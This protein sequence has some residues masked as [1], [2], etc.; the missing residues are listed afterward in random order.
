MRND[1]LG[2][3]FSNINDSLMPQLTEQRCL[4]SVPFGGRY[5]LIDFALSN[6]VSCGV[7][8]VGI[9]TRSNYRSLMDHIKSGKQWDLARKEGGVFFISPYAF[10]NGMYRDRLEALYGADGFIRKSRSKYIVFTDCNYVCNIDIEAMIDAHEKSGADITAAYKNGVCP[11]TASGKLCFTKIDANGRVNEIK[12]L[13]KGDI[14]NFAVNIYVIEKNLF[15]DILEKS[16][17]KGYT[18]I[19]R[20]IFQKNVE[21]LNINAYNI[22]SSVLCIDSMQSYFDCSMKLLDSAK[23]RTEIL[24]N[25]HSVLTKVRDEMPAKYGMNAKASNSLISNGC[26][27]DGEVENCILFR[28]VKVGKGT[29]L[30]N[31]IV[32]QG[33]EI[34]E[35][36][37]LSYVIAD[38]N[39]VIDRAPS[40][41]GS[42][43][44]PLYIK[45]GTHI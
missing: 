34:G 12:L 38:K 40:L 45:K 30:S 25:H 5:R 31:C 20:D 26:V 14:Q 27:I 36:I 15:L 7:S 29:R 9:I 28:E 42:P 24:D 10:G 22:T 33:C 2:I 6:L 17:S 19:E 43:Y 32:M 39:V 8:N 41:N 44:Y 37:D 3:I 35:N 4:G 23:T 1:V 11:D 16:K 18:N 21:N 13:P